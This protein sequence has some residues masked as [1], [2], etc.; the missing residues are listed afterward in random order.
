MI[1]FVA[2]F[3]ILDYLD[4]LKV[5]KETYREY[6]CLCPV[7]GD[8]GFKINKSNGK[9]QAFKCG[10]EV[11][12]I[13]EAVRPWS[14]VK[15]MQ[16][17][18]GGFPHERLHQEESQT[19]KRV[20]PNKQRINH[21]TPTP[22]STSEKKINLAR[23]SENQD[24][25]PQPKSETIPKWLVE[26]GVPVSAVEIRYW[27]SKSQWVSRFEWKNGDGI[28]EK[29]IRQGSIKSNGL[30][31]WKKGSKDWRAYR[32]S[33]AVKH[34]QDKWILGVEGEGCVEVA[35]GMAIA[36]ITWQGSNWK[37]KSIADD[38]T[39]LIE[40]GAAGLVYFP[41]FDSAGEKKAELIKSACG[42]VNLPCLILSPTDVWGEMP[43]KGDIT[44]FVSAHQE[45]STKQLVARISS[46]IAIA[47][48]RDEQEKQKKEEEERLANLPD[49]SQSDIA[50]W[51]AE[52]YREQLAWNVDEQ[53]WYRYSS[54][55]SGIWSVESVEL[56]GQLV[57]SQVKAIAYETVRLGKKKPSY[58]ISF[59]N[60]V[61]A[62]LKL[63]LA[64]RRWNEASGL[65]PMLNGVLDLETKKLMPHS[66]ENKLTW[67]LPY[68]YNILATCEPIQEWLLSM[69][70]GDRCIVE[71][72]RA[73]LLGI[74]TGRTDWQKF[75]ELIGPGGT[76]KSTF[77]RLATA[78]VGTENVHTTTL[79]KLEKSKFECASI[80]GK[81]LVLINDS[82]KYAGEV[83]RLKNLT[84]Q[85]GLPYEVK[86]KQS[87]GGFNPDA[88][89]IVST[90]EVIQSS[91][92][93]SGLARR[94]ISIPMFNQIK[95][96]R[97]K[98]LIEHKNGEMYGDF[99]PYIPGLLNWVLAMDEKSATEIVK[100]YEE[101]VPSLLAMKSRTL[102]ETN[103]IAD[104]LDN[105]VVYQAEA[106]TNI[107]VA[108]RDK[109]SI[110]LRKNIRTFFENCIY[111]ISYSI[112]FD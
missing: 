13:R 30:K 62:L 63:D 89:V 6:H 112:K 10:C 25:S 49:W 5:V 111:T 33:E 21:Q 17:G 55:R 43:H 7:C 70:G 90:N 78:L 2:P 101:N 103:P 34:C 67:C 80:A 105:F 81:R 60:G 29:T 88:L 91:D 66:P 48:K 100:N 42:A 16:R 19:P 65:L 45:L 61:T 54:L 1:G 72:M 82:E 23:L 99:L 39:K 98:N 104:W 68:K 44:D 76:G 35:R 56:I 32:L 8:G 83:V 51:L 92:Y 53:E 52:K 93:T 110:A 59:I 28:T 74:L 96:N 85:D 47:D 109:D 20:K 22:A 37:E 31:E 12:E 38:V 15:A 50:E 40:A 73:Y 75:I 41:D 24:D 84:G 26:Q 71:L 9:Y 36:S 46:A 14:E 106:R 102:V 87:K 11:K 86:F 94:R 69:C 77:T 108:K 64:V 57:K 97:Q 27:Y 18:L 95:G 4:R 3:Q 79:H 107:G 58:T